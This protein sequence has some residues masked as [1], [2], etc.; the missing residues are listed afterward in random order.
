MH[1]VT[2]QESGKI[3]GPRTEFCGTHAPRLIGGVIKNTEDVVGENLCYRFSHTTE[4]GQ[5]K[6]DRI[7]TKKIKR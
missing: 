5:E 7:P 6:I 1:S 4:T 3:L 2:S